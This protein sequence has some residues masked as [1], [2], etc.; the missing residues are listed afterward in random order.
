[1][2]PYLRQAFDLRN[3]PEY[4]SQRMLNALYVYDE[5]RLAHILKTSHYCSRIPKPTA[6]ENENENENLM[7]LPLLDNELRC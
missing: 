5:S 7:S 6:M 3:T 1:M 2:Y 4:T